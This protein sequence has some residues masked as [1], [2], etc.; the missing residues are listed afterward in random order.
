MVTYNIIIGHHKKLHTIA[1]LG[2]SIRL[3]ITMESY[4]GFAQA[5]EYLKLAARSTYLASVVIQ[6]GYATGRQLFPCKCLGKKNLVRMTSIV[7]HAVIAHTLA[8][9][10]RVH[11]ASAKQVTFPELYAHFQDRGIAPVAKGKL[12]VRRE[13]KTLAS[14]YS[15]S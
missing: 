12:Q 10:Y 14:R 3:N 9:S 11:V 2:S 8:R 13:M 4:N 1:A 6:P 5:D 7:W 15:A